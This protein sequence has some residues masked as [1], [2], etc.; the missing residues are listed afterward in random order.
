[1]STLCEHCRRQAPTEAFCVV[2]SVLIRRLHY[3]AECMQLILAERRAVIPPDMYALWPV[4]YEV[5]RETWPKFCEVASLGEIRHMAAR[6]MSIIR[7]FDQHLP[8]EFAGLALLESAKG[9]RSTSRFT[10]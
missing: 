3:C 6:L 7:Y 9:E 4:D 2:G 5:L 8:P 10:A 1:M